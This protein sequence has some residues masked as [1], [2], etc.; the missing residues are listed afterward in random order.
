M[1]IKT[2]LL[3]ALSFAT[4]LPVLIVGIAVAILNSQQAVHDFDES[5]TQTL[6]AVE[7]T[8]E[9]FVTDIK[10]TVAFMSKADAVTNPNAPLFTTYA[11]KQGKAPAEIARKNGG[12]ELEV[13][14]LF[15]DLGTS[16]PNLVYV[17]MGDTGN[18]YMEWPGTYGYAEWNP[19]ER[20]WYTIA[21]KNQGKV[22]MRPA[23]YW[24]PDDAVYVSAVSSFKR[25]NKFAGV[26]AIDF[27]IKKL[28]EMAKNT[29][30]GDTGTLMV[31][32]DTGAILVDVIN[33]DNSFKNINEM[34][35]PAYKQI[36]SSK[37]GMFDVS[38]NGAAYKAKIL[39]SP[40]LN[41]K[42]VALMPEQEI[43]AATND[44]IQTT[45]VI[46]IVL[47]AGFILISFVLAN[48]LVTPIVAVSDSLKVIAEGEGDLTAKIDIKTQ[49]ETGTLAQWFNQF[50]QS[51]RA[52]ILEIKGAA[53]DINS[54]ATLTAQKA[55]EVDHATSDQGLAL[56][57]IAQAG[58][59]M[60]E[61]ANEA[62]QSCTESAQFSEQVLE[63][64]VSGKTL[65]KDSTDSVTRLTKRLQD[66]N[67]V[68]A[69][70]ENETGNINQILSTIGDIAEQTNLLALNA[71]IE[72]AR[73]GEQ[74]RGFA[75][76]ADE[77]RGLAQRTQE[78]TEQIASILGL[79][80]G[81]TRAASQAMV[82]CL[83]E[84]EHASAASD[85]AIASF[86]KIEDV[87]K[88]MHDMTMRTATSANEQQA[89]TADINGHIAN[90]TRS[91]TDISTISAELADL[92][93][94]QENLS[95]N[96]NGIVSR[97]RT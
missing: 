84:S 80:S 28:T 23:Y 47:L 73:A 25:N 31:I 53:G 85:Q 50:L 2:K 95:K 65:I 76:V 3:L 1:R 59:Q 39:T 51:T 27:S 91:A 35:D 13:Y 43:F 69:E 57:Q 11:E 66:S 10:Y 92:C 19:K 45:V 6:S 38:I 55:Q 89:V 83:N 15:E 40:N 72:A 52:M 4:V 97:F 48:R 8:F 75:V 63:T 94:K 9:Q 5:S 56:Q 7:K 22:M 82:D 86:H 44:M 61:A 96:V 18:G 32:E 49:D 81:R 26:V 33:P 12:S 34:S 67:A 88:Q 78:S 87:V 64:T 79:L 42:F 41:W 60:L 71:A 30:I 54:T 36:A 68:I 20:P 62:A 14:N 74:G 24:E 90:I 46:C 70:L 16:N 29:P 93:K 58:E 37:S 21:E 77:V 17:Y